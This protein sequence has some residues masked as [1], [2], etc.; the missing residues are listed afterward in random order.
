MTN[1]GMT[2]GWVGAR[3]K[4]FLLAALMAGP[5]SAMAVPPRV[6]WTASASDGQDGEFPAAAAIDGRDD[7]RWSSPFED[8]HHLAVDLGRAATVAGLRIAWE[9][10][11]ASAYRVETSADGRAWQVARRVDPGDGH[12]DRIYFPTVTARHVRILVE[13]RATGWGASLWEL[14]VLGPD[15]AP[16]VAGETRLPAGEVA[17]R[18][19]PVASEAVLELEWPAPEAISGLRVDWARAAQRDLRWEL[20]DEAGAWRTADTLSG[21]EGDFDLLMHDLR[22]VRRA[23]LAMRAEDPADLRINALSP[24]GPGEERTPLALYERA[25]AKAP[26][27][28]YPEALRQGQVYWTVVGLPDSAHEALLDEYGNL[29]AFS[30]GPAL[31][32]YL[33]IGGRLVTPLD[34]ASITQSLAAGHLPLPSVEW[35]AGDARLRIDAIPDRVED[36]AATLAR[37]T[38]T[39]DGGAALEGELLLALRPLQINPKWQHGGASP[40]RRVLIRPEGDATRI[41]VDGWGY[42]M[43]PAADAAMAAPYAGGDVVHAAA[44]GAWSGAAGAD[45]PAG[46]ISVASLH[47]FRL[48]P[49]ASTSVVVTVSGDGAPPAAVGPDEFAARRAASESAWRGR[50]RRARIALGDRDV[51]DTLYAQAGYILVNRDGVA[52]QPGSRNYNRVWIRDGALTASALL[53]LGLAEEAVDYVDWYARAVRE[54][55]LVPPILNTDG[56]VHEGFGSN[57]EYDAQGQFIFIV[58]ETARFTGDDA[59]LRRHYPAVLRAMRCM[60]TLRE[61]TLADDYAAGD[62]RRARYRG[63]LPASISHEGYSTP[64][65]SYW[66]D[67]WALRGWRDGAELARRMGEEKTAKWADEQYALLVASVRA[68]LALT[69]Q[70]CGITHIP[71]SAERG[72]PD[73]TSV[74]SAFFPCEVAG[75]VFEPEAIAKTYDDYLADIARRGA[76][77]AAW[78]YTPYEARNI[79][80][81][82]VMGRIGDARALHD[83]L[84]RDRRPPGWRHFA[85]VVTSD[86]RRGTY[87]GD[88]P[89]TWVGAEYAVSVRTMLVRETGDDLRLLEGAPTAWWRGGGFALEAMPTRFGP[90]HLKIERSED[91]CAVSLKTPPRLTGRIRFYAP[92]ELPLARVEVDGRV[93]AASAR[94]PAGYY[95]WS[96][97]PERP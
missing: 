60:R 57:L 11:F 12:L 41:A 59:L 36:R 44:R 54:D 5:L 40:I 96:R 35:R 16:R 65:H 89:H 27:G 14:D 78:L 92:A 4:G 10:A 28:W 88:M 90:L 71:G 70:E 1:D 58:A 19:Q 73:A 80:A 31:M 24:R 21:S 38:V 18:W 3:V 83:R 62:P 50:V 84:F 8:G 34:A 68:S 64:H 13:R 7:T 77:D 87:I 82:Q 79:A 39:A 23:R 37:Y 51:S 9:A 29:E 43:R 26:P 17:A 48:A 45:E 52:L 2:K 20:E 91:G 46:M 49:G 76:G 97:E 81:L 75:E 53:R 86:P 95:E 6:E 66:D 32:P 72:D 25:A 22:T 69:M 15:D 30:R 56:T 55:G 67:Y 47:T 74:S 42:A 85:E 61:R 94:N 33:R 63:L 93:L